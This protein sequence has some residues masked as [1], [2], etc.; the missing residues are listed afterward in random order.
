MKVLKSITSQEA[1]K[2]ARYN[3]LSSGGYVRCSVVSKDAARHSDANLYGE[4]TA[5]ARDAIV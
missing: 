1:I 5:D 2:N 4:A 3:G